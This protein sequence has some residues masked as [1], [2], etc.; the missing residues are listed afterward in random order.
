M[1][2]CVRKFVFNGKNDKKGWALCCKIMYL[3]VLVF[4][5]VWIIVGSVQLF[6]DD[7]CYDTYYSMFAMVLAILVMSY[8]GISVFLLACCAACVFGVG[9]SF[10]PGMRMRRQQRNN[11]S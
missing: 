11:N 6:T 1:A 2:F 5:L 10:V 9:L 4:N 7:S 3:I 8:I